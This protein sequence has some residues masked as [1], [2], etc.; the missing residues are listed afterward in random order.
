MGVFLLCILGFFS[1]SEGT[2]TLL[3]REVAERA[4]H[5]DEVLILEQDS[6]PLTQTFDLIAAYQPSQEELAKIQAA[7]KPGGI[8]LL[9]FHPTTSYHWQIP[10][11]APEKYKIE[12]KIKQK[13][14][15]KDIAGY[16]DYNELIEEMQNYPQIWGFPQDP[17]ALAQKAADWTWFPKHLGLPYYTVMFVLTN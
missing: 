14:F 12:L 8:C 5:D 4:K 10:E 15:Y 13:R 9:M 16:K 17:H 2:K 1:I 6:T 3:L 11:K 7:L